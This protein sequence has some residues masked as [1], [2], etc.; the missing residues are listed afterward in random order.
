MKVAFVTVAAL[1]LICT[2]CVSPSGS[3]QDAIHTTFRHTVPGA[4][5][6]DGDW[7]EDLPD[8]PAKE[9]SEVLRE[10]LRS[11][12]EEFTL[13]FVQRLLLSLL[14]R[15]L[16]DRDCRGTRKQAVRSALLGAGVEI[17]DRRLFGPRMER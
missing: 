11:S 2:G 7:R 12:I 10:E 1:C 16:A 15:E 3:S 6:Q 4:F 17:T 5:A 8:R 13:E 14:E 9:R